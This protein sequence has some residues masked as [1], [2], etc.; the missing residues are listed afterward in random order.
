MRPKKN[1]L[2]WLW[3]RIGEHK[4]KKKKKESSLKAPSYPNINIFPQLLLYMHYKSVYL[5]LPEAKPNTSLGSRSCP[6]IWSSKHDLQTKYFSLH[7]KQQSSQRKEWSS[8]IVWIYNYLKA[9]VI[10]FSTITMTYITIKGK[11]PG[12][13]NGCVSL[14]L[15][16]KC[17]NKGKS[18]LCLPKSSLRCSIST[19]SNPTKLRF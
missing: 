1:W 8:K 13:H 19:T 16:F 15:R 6:V 9:S 3:R 14:S 17:E 2:P 5:H 4:E 10:Y 12:Q 18:G 11:P 7:W